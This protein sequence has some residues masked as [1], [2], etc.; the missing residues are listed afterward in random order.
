[1]DAVVII[2]AYD[3][4]EKLITIV[5]KVQALGHQVLVV[6]DGSKTEK[7]GL[8]Q[9]VEADAIVLHHDQNRG[10][11]AAIKTALTYI[12]NNLPTCDV[13]GVMDADGQHLPDDMEKLLLVAEKNE[14]CLVLGVRHVGQDMPFR[15]RFGNGLTRGIFHILSG[16]KVSDTQTGMRAFSKKLLNSFLLVE[17]DRYEYETNILIYCAKNEI[18][19]E[20]IPIQT[21]YIDRDN[22]S[23]HFR[24]V[25]DSLRIYK[26][27]FK[28]A[29]SSL[30]SFILDYI[31]FCIFVWLYPSGTVYVLYANIIARLISGAYN[32][33]LNCRFV[34]HSG[35]KWKTALQY[36]CLAVGILCL[37]SLI[38]HFYNGIL[39]IPVY[40]AKILTELSLFI[41]SFLVQKKLIF[42]GR[43]NA[44]NKKEVPQICGK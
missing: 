17:G 7:R 18:A 37:N 11:G 20:E 24:I 30:S 41:I 8:F 32:Y 40:A 31:L 33:F 4:D 43:R 26:D 44:G 27:L 15:S 6:D 12:D 10:K 36:V 42:A 39:H 34:F 38:L 28:F 9:T 2:P 19:F 16:V 13:V 1:M 25:R 5:D 22:S 35:A 29:A 21:I 23:S 3:P 14:A